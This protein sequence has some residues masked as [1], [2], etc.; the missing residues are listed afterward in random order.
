MRVAIA[1]GSGFIGKRLADALQAQG[2]EPILI[3]RTAKAGQE[4]GWKTLTWDELERLDRPLAL[5]PPDAVVNL[6]GE[7]INQRWTAAAKSRIIRSRVEST[8][9]LFR[10]LRALNRY[11]SVFVQGSAIGYY[12]VSETAT[13]D[14]QSPPGG[15]DFL[16]QVAQEWE[17][18]ADDNRI[19]GIRLVKLRTG[20]VLDGR[21]G[22]LPRILQPYRFFTGGR[23]GSG[24]QVYSWIHIDDLIGLI[25]WTI[26]TESVQ[27]AVN[28]TAPSPV[29]NDR[30]GRAV[31]S[32]L[33]RPHWLPV[34]GS[35]LK[36]ALGEMS[37]LVLYG[38]R[39][40]PSAALAGGYRFRHPELEEALRHLLR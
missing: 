1:G 37:L 16:S 26:R 8:R 38:Q 28:G 15:G 31:S 32:V 19:P 21:E 10:W 25:L 33:R 35:V 27:G 3:S 14:E 2:D 17:Q 22:A 4:R 12:G 13:F 18:A 30:F 9:R 7:T 34:P 6:A 24:S 23:I 39:V 11:P 5:D 20:L 36:A 29:T 40:I